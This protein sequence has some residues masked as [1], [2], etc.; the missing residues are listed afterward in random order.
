MFCTVI[1][2]DLINASMSLKELPITMHVTQ[3]CDRSLICLGIYLYLLLTFITNIL[4]LL[5]DVIV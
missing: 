1:D 3:T 5:F 4:Y 2:N